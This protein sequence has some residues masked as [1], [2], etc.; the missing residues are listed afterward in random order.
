MKGGNVYGVQEKCQTERV[1][2]S[3]DA[4]GTR[5]RRKYHEQY[6]LTSSLSQSPKGC[7]AVA[8]VE[9]AGA[10]TKLQ[11]STP[12]RDQSKDVIIVVRAAATVVRAA[13][14]VVRATATVVRSA[15]PC[16]P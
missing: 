4:R 8:L 16:M 7:A 13:A 10:V 1:R 3:V 6:V 9:P 12:A 11:I 15:A 5:N 14:T 2:A